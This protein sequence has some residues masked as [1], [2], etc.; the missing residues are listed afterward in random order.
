MGGDLESIFGIDREIVLT[1]IRNLNETQ[2]FE[3]GNPQLAADPTHGQAVS[4]LGPRNASM[5]T[6]RVKG[7]RGSIGYIEPYCSP[8]PLV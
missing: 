1:R 6:P 4:F 2:D 8:P 3:R 5:P 7:S